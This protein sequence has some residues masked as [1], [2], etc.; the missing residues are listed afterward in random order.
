MNVR[1]LKT[2][3]YLYLYLIFLKQY[4]KTQMQS[5]ADFFIGFFSFFLNQIMGIVFLY[6]VF[7]QIPDLN[8][9]SFYE[10]V[11][12]YGYAQIPRGLDHFFTNYLWI[13][14]RKTVREGLFDR[15][16]LRPVNPLFQVLMEQCCVD[17]I[18]EFLVGLLLVTAA[19]MHLG[20]TLSVANI[21]LFVI[22]VIFG[23]LIYSSVK[24]LLATNTFF[25]TDA[26][27]I[28]YL[29]YNLSD[30]A[31]YPLEIYAKP[32]RYILSFVIP[33]GFT[34]F[35]PASYFLRMGTIARTIGAEVIVS[36]LLFVLAYRF[37]CFG[38]NRYQS[39]GN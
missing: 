16:L 21:L 8:G 5:G 2:G 37:F 28:L 6:L 14:T 30:F 22:S 36:V 31:K 35:I 39:C 3:R 27:Q 26:Y 18:G 17:G 19:V 15:Y 12:I 20:I 29:G 13:F 9:W 10:L 38:C 7:E 25:I 34:A 23:A 32:I 1:K 4:L 33:F 24:I 11:F